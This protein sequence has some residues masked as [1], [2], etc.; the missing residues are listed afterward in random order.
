MKS[1][2]AIAAGE[3]YEEE[4]SML[5][6]QLEFSFIGEGGFTVSRPH[7]AVREQG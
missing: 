1:I 3:Q 2:I 7:D 6:P 4:A 5:T